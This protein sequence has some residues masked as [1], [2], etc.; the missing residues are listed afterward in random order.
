M[1]GGDVIEE[2]GSGKEIW[3]WNI[4]MIKLYIINV[5]A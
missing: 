1:Y 5:R 2:D 3:M 4:G